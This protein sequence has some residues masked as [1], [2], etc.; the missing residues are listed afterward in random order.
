MVELTLKRSDS[1]VVLHVWGLPEWLYTVVKRDVWRK[2]AKID[3]WGGL[4]PVDPRLNAHIGGV[5]VALI[6]H[7]DLWILASTDAYNR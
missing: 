5:S 1:F 3:E 4:Q 6:L 7:C 2:G